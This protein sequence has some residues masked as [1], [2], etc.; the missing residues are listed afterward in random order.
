MNFVTFEELNNCIYSNLGKLPRDIDLIVGIPRSGTMVGNILALYLNLPF[1]D[2]D[3]FINRGAL[4]S[5][6]T[7]KCEGWIKKIDEAKHVLI[8][9]DSISSGKAIKEVKEQIAA[10]GIKH[11]KIEYLAIYAL[12]VSSP[13]VNYYFKICEQPRM[14][15]WNY[16]H[17]WM[18]EYTCMDIDGVLCEDPKY[19]E[20]DDG[21]KYLEFIHNAVPKMIPTMTVGN[22]VSCRLEKYRHETEEWLNRNNVK[23]NNLILLDSISAKER[24]LNFDHAKY[25]ADYYV[26]SNCAL[27]IE[28][29]K[30]QAI[31]IC[32]YSKKPVFC[33]E[34]RTLYKPDSIQ[35][36]IS[37]KGRDF[38]LTFKRAVKKIMGKINYVQ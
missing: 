13:K 4:R 37:M 8:V 32:N 30:E 1:T 7:R 31:N 38:K 33:V 2:V 25:K 35:G 18:L 9:D 28:S 10:R 15:E 27:F 34:N 26:K 24:K 14:F 29:D 20:N 11:E 21:A 17:H 19:Y 16:M 12:K 5:G 36:I 3:N 6:T 23:Y 22:L